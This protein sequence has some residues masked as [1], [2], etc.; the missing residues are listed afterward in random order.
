MLLNQQVDVV[1]A[2]SAPDR[3]V[4]VAALAKGFKK[5]FRFFRAGNLMVVD[6]QQQIAA[7]QAHLRKNAARFESGNA[8]PHLTIEKAGGR[9]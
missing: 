3:E 4:D 1:G 6:R 9:A 8:K 2:G 5:R 7:A